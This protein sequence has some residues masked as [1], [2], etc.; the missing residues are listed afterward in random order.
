MLCQKCKQREAVYYYTEN[1]NGTVKS[2]A[3]C[4]ECKKNNISF[5]NHYKAQSF[6]PFYGLQIPSSFFFG[7]SAPLNKRCEHC[8]ATW[9]TLS[10]GDADFCPECFDT[11]RKELSALLL[12]IHSSNKYLGKLPVKSILNADCDLN[13]SQSANDTKDAEILDGLKRDLDT[14]IREERYEDAAKIRDKIKDL[15]K[16]ENNNE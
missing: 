9:T 5:E 4:E 7:G 15:N 16:K 1:I 10:N 6:D 13:I 14:A 3:L 12:K 11:F 8:G 2:I